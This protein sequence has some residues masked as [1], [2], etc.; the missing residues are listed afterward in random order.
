VACSTSAVTLP[1]F[2][3][4]RRGAHGDFCFAGALILFV[5]L[6]AVFCATLE[7]LQ[8]VTFHVYEV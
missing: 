3:L 6:S 7:F 8:P 1:P 5:H 4:A 2:C